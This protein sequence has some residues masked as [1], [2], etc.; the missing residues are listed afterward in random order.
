MLLL[1]SSGREGIKNLP[2]P[3]V[4][5][6][7]GRKENRV[8]T[9]IAR[10]SSRTTQCRAIEGASLRLLAESSGNGKARAFTGSHPPPALCQGAAA[11]VPITAHNQLC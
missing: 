4:L 3:S 2:N 5:L 1:F 11:A 6:Y 8:A 9:Q 10:E 7:M